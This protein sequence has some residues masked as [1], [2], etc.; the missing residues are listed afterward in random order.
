MAGQVLILGCGYTGVRVARRCLDRGMR[1][2]V[3]TRDPARLHEL[4]QAGATVYPLEAQSAASLR[5][6]RDMLDPDA[7]VLHSLP[8][9]ERADAPHD[10]TPAL[11]EALGA[12]AARLV[13][14]S[15]TGVYGAATRV[16]ERTPIQ[17]VTLRQQLRA[18]A[19]HAVL[20]GVRSALVLRPAAIYGPG[21]GTLESIRVGRYRLVGDGSNV[22]SFIHVDDLAAHAEAA[23]FSTLTGAY[24]VADDHP[25]PAR[26]VAAYCA[27]LLD[28]PMPPSMPIEQA[29]ETQRFTRAVDGR[30]IRRALGITLRYPSYLIGA[31]SSLTD[32]SAPVVA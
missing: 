18:A 7:I 1:V 23:L 9:I 3:T 12:R 30:A 31:P 28:A 25:S 15:T 17:P 16:D 5:G 11:I 8:L 26:E 14:L 2:V 13:Y 24:P 21:R 22:T 32:A 4:A 10:P 19:E 6:L 20:A 27:A 29:H